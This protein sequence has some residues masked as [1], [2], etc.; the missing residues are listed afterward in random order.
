MPPITFWRDWKTRISQRER[1]T[2]ALGT[3][4]N[5]CNRS[6]SHANRNKH[7]QERPNVAGGLVGANLANGRADFTGRGRFFKTFIASVAHSIAIPARQRLEWENIS[8]MKI[9]S[10]PFRVTI[11]HYDTKVTLEKDRSDLDIHEVAELLATALM[12]AGYAEKTVEEII[13]VEF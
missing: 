12:A 11:E 6:K 13:K 2:F 9:E 3:N 4:Q 8:I 7:S 5:R 10:Q 1:F